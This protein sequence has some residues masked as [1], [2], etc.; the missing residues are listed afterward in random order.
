M[1]T[2]PIKS[3]KNFVDDEKINLGKSSCLKIT[4]FSEEFWEKRYS[5]S[6][7]PCLNAKRMI[8]GYNTFLEET[9]N[10]KT[11]ILP[12]VVREI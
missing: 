12:D 4:G 8:K 1:G 10:S 5:D 7:P 9:K 3:S 2:V 11:G 6:T